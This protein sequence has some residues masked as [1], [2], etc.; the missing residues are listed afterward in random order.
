MFFVLH[1]SI[2][3]GRSVGVTLV[4]RGYSGVYHCFTTVLG[5]SAV[6]VA[7]PCS[8]VPCS[9]VPGFIVCLNI[10]KFC[11]LKSL[12]LQIH[13]K[14]DFKVKTFLKSWL[15]FQFFEFL[16][17]GTSSRKVLGIMPIKV[18]KDNF[19]EKLLRS[20]RYTFTKRFYLSHFGF[21]GPLVSHGSS[22]AICRICFL[23]ISTK[24]HVSNRKAP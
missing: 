5:C 19:Y 20:S 1:A 15:I 16:L 6:S 21:S 18:I 23:H 10:S 12:P 7:V 11:Y 14:I 9:D 2:V 13:A 22:F 8:T 3:T 24:I 4:F 17:P